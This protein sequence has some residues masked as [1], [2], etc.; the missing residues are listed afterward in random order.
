MY[1][2]IETWG[3]IEGE[4]RQIN[5]IRR[6][7]RMSK[8]SHHSQLT[9]HAVGYVRR[10]TDRQEQSIGDQK[11][12]IHAYVESHGFHLL[13]CYVDDA[14][15]GT[16]V[17]GRRAFLQMIE[18]AKSP[19]KTF[20]S[21]VV[22]DV[23][24]FGRID[25]DEAGYYRHVLRMHGVSVHYIS[26]NFKGD[27]TDDL[28]RPVKQWQARQESKD[29]S[30]V[31]IRGL[32][33]KTDDEKGWWMGGVPPYGYD[34]RYE[35]LDGEFL[36]ILRY[37]P[38]RTKLVLDGKGKVTRI[39]SRGERL[40]ISKRD[41]ARLFPSSSDRVQVIKSIFSMYTE[42]AKG[43]KAIAASLNDN[44]IP[45]PRSPKW[46][47]IYKGAWT[48]TTI[49]AI[50]V[51]P[52][53]A[54]DMVWNRRTDARFH[55]IKDGRAVE[56]ECMHG[57]RLVPNDECDWIIQ[58]DTHPPLISRRT[59][60]EARIQRNCKPSSFE[61]QGRDPRRKT[62]GKSWKGQRSRFILS[63]LLT[64]KI[65]G[66]RYQGVTRHKGKR[67]IDGTRVT[68]SFYGCGGHITKG[69][70]ICQM[71][72]IPQEVLENIVIESV[73]EYYQS[74]L[75]D[76]GHQ[77]L[78]E[79]VEKQVQMEGTEL[80]QKRHCIQE[81]EERLSETINQLL[82]NITAT[83]KDF[84]DKRLKELKAQ[85]ELLK[86][87]L[88][89]LEQLAMSQTQIQSIVTEAFE[90]LGSLDFTLSKGL[91]QEKLS[92]LRQ[93]IER[94]YINIPSKEIDL[95]LRIVPIANLLKTL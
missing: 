73:L 84:V 55:Q 87:R 42:Q 62:H 26:E 1:G 41:R 31:T 51:N 7:S 27:T 74:Y 64:C 28:L 35:S 5:C 48:D 93:S 95:M 65:C 13:K 2:A 30:K 52:L 75:N 50:I 90:F 76:S 39:L 24:R 53:Y 80:T 32:L 82:D 20:D 81:E 40:S 22:Y 16:S 83:N 54:G 92:L 17:L 77:K 12:A 45:P 70:A 19:V 6:I 47:Y 37:E 85:R 72:A 79:A 57:A 91:P 10:S 29:L 63:G 8:Q 59:F 61:Q 60:E 46:S 86:Q 49:R 34:L 43:Y 69:N 33:S 67:R 88:T 68:T 38:D 71:N 3:T 21:V 11:E 36:L 66:N 58:R 14:I 23:K 25:N 56:R 9:N 15:S 89:E 78:S 18:D 4:K 44:K 94:I